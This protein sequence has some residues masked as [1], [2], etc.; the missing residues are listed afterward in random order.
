MY[1]IKI[2]GRFLPPRVIGESGT[3]IILVLVHFSENIVLLVGFQVKDII[4]ILDEVYLS[5]VVG[6]SGTCI[7]VQGCLIMVTENTG[8]W[9]RSNCRYF[10]SMV[11]NKYVTYTSYVKR[12]KYETVDLVNE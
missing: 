8:T 12:L 10:T 4:K 7:I 6:R 11:I 9:I 1:S 3:C 5:R 2:L